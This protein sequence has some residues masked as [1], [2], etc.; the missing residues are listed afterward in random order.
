MVAKGLDRTG[1][2]ARSVEQ[3]ESAARMTLAAQ[4]PTCTHLAIDGQ[5]APAFGRTTTTIV[6]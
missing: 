4:Q 3:I 1:A 5:P 2:E 6:H